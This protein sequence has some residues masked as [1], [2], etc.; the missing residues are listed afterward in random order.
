MEGALP[1][2]V[3]NPR[4]RRRARA[5]REPREIPLDRDAQLLLMTNGSW[6]ERDGP[7]RPE[8]EQSTLDRMPAPD[9]PAV[10][11]ELRRAKGEQRRAAEQ[12]QLAPAA[13]PARADAAAGEAVDR[14]PVG[15]AGGGGTGLD[16][17][18]HSPSRKH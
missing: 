4:P 8:R 14:L 15:D 16:P 13:G 3:E 12:L 11:R 2:H 5:G 7:S 6:C 9:D 17:P 10:G 18:A 1:L